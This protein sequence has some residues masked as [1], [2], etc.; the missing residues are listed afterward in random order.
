MGEEIA[1]PVKWFNEN[2][3]SLVEPLALKNENMIGYRKLLV[4]FTKLL[5]GSGK[6]LDAGCGWGRDVNY[7]VQNGFN[8]HGIDKAQ[9]PLNYG[10]KEY[11]IEDINERLKKMDVTELDF[12]D[13]TFDGIWCN[14]LI[15]FYPPENMVEPVSE[16]SRVLKDKGILYISFKLSETGELESSIREEN[17]GS[18]IKRYLMPPEKIQKL[19][20]K[21]DLEIIR[22]HSEIER[23]KFEHPVWNI[24]CRKI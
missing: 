4:K 23:D 2:F 1:D 22:E 3:E 12:K 18:K 24:F 13:Q 6:I 11:P 14:S 17:D 15:H 19:L 16:L 10:I 20:K 21:Q 9:K 5:D 8:A 7:F